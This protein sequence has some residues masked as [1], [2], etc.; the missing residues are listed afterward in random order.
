[1]NQTMTITQP[2]HYAEQVRNLVEIMEEFQGS[3]Q[4]IDP[5]SKNLIRWGTGVLREVAQHRSDSAEAISR[6]AAAQIA[7][8]NT[9]HLVCQ[10][11]GEPLCDD[12]TKERDWTLKRLVHRDVRRLFNG[13]SPLDGKMM[14][15]QPPTHEFAKKM[16]AWANTFQPSAMPSEERQMVLLNPD[17]SKDQARRF[18]YER[19]ATA[20]KLVRQ[21]QLLQ[22]T[23]DSALVLVENQMTTMHI[24]GQQ[25]MVEAQ[26][27]ADLHE[28]A[29]RKQ[30]ENL[31]ATHHGRIEALASQIS[32][33]EKT[34][35]ENVANLEG[36]I[37]LKDEVDKAAAA[38]LRKQVEE[39]QQSHQKTV[40]ALGSRI[41]SLNQVHK[42]DVTRLETQL[43]SAQS[44]MSSMT[45]THR[46][47]V[48]GL[49][50]Q[51]AN[52]SVELQRVSTLFNEAQTRTAQHT[53][54]F[55]QLQQAYSQSQNTIRI[56]QDEV[57]D[58]NDSSCGIM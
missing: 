21:Q 26:K 37:A 28:A 34:H 6:V 14:A 39:I 8:L 54:D 10:L 27:K 32:N 17:P 24:S 48:S 57:S 11:S 44:A 51:L 1:M 9:E 12:P 4:Y 30:I 33:I 20:A 47:T 38:A 15:E 18:V 49:E 23:M 42:Q 43:N 46:Q 31:Q 2:R 7:V 58:A 40:E 13:A 29:L 52:R 50:A 53:D 36:Q 16:V 22:Q 55:K 19:L 5:L 45:Q 3:P 25:A 41:D 35:R 56:L